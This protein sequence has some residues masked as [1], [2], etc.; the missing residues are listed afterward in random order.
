MS[1]AFKSAQHSLNWKALQIKKMNKKQPCKQFSDEERAALASQYGMQVSSKPPVPLKQRK[2][3]VAADVM[4]DDEID[5]DAL[6][7]GLAEKLGLTT[8][9]EE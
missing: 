2:P 5:V 9:D 4:V 1:D 3:K 6:P 7:E 8:T